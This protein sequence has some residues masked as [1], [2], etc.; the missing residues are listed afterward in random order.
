MFMR[1]FD[2]LL[3]S[4]TWQPFI[5]GRS[6]LHRTKGIKDRGFKRRVLLI[7]DFFNRIRENLHSIPRIFR[8]E[9]DVF[10]EG[11]WYEEPP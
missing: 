10:W 5:A 6:Y 4:T 3:F 2:A 9:L 8:M 1:Q 11:K 7:L